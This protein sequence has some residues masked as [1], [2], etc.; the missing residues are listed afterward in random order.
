M[1]KAQ[2]KSIGLLFG[3]CL[4]TACQPKLTPEQVYEAYSADVLSADQLSDV[5]Y[6]ELLSERAQRSLVQSLQLSSEKAVDFDLSI[7]FDGKPAEVT[8]KQIVVH[9]DTNQ[10]QDMLLR[11][12]KSDVE[13]PDEHSQTLNVQDKTAQLVFE[14]ADPLNEGGQATQKVE[15]INEDG[16]KIDGIE[17][18]VKFAAGNFYST[19]TYR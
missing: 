3:F 18:E 9:A 4:I 7:A 14:Y 13:L 8:D 16:W 10:L 17:R 15:L 1:N 6:S 19:Q 11:M 5:A 2:I 12:F